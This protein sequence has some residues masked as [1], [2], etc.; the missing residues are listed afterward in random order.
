MER[1][2]KTIIA[3]RFSGLLYKCKK[4]ALDMGVSY[5]CIYYILKGRN[6]LSL[7]RFIQLCQEARLDPVKELKSIIA[8]LNKEAKNDK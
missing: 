6:A 8:E 2:L 5:Q 7:A 3:R 4:I 1:K